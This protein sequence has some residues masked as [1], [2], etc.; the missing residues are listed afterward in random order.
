MDQE[1]ERIQQDF[2]DISGKLNRRI[3]MLSQSKTIDISDLHEG[4]YIVK[5]LID[6]KVFVEKLIINR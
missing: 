5:I 3:D 1:R 4:M 2:I 6:K